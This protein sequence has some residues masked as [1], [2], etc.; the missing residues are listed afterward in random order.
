MTA[1]LP[2]ARHG[3][4]DERQAGGPAPSIDGHE[5]LETKDGRKSYLDRTLIEERGDSVAFVE[6]EQVLQG[7][8]IPDARFVVLFTYALDDQGH[9]T[10]DTASLPEEAAKLPARLGRVIE[11][12]HAAGISQVDVVTDHGFLW[13]DPEDVDALQHPSVP[14]AQVVSKNQRYMILERGAMTSD[15]VRLPLP[16]N[17]SVEVGFPRGVRTFT[18]ASWYLHGGLSSARVGDPARDLARR[19]AAAP[20]RGRVPRDVYRA[21]RGD[22]RGEGATGRR[23]SRGRA[24]AP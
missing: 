20:R 14:A 19:C 13:M 10:A 1:L 16:F 4:R 24:A 12:L 18:K 7:D 5:G 17:G 15:V 21:V 2:G 3:D 23:C 11:R 6:L 22:D 9:S 8:P